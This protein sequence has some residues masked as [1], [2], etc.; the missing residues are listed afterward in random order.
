MIQGCWQRFRGLAKKATVVYSAL[1]AMLA[2]QALL[3]N[4]PSLLRKIGA[5]RY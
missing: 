2:L 1:I 5:Y 4:R 3:L